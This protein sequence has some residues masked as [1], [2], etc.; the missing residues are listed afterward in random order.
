M[1]CQLTTMPRAPEGA[2]PICPPPLS[3]TSLISCLRAC[4]STTS[5]APS[6]FRHRRR[7]F[8]KGH[9]CNGPCIAEN[10]LQSLEN[11][12]KW[13]IRKGLEGHSIEDLLPLLAGACVQT[14]QTNGVC[15]RRVCNNQKGAR[16]PPL[17]ALPACRSWLCAQ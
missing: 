5:H 14:R 6:P 15:R 12:A 3:L 16:V 8:H 13:L 1:Q 7:H 17:A 4:T 11:L 9:N 10:F 2:T